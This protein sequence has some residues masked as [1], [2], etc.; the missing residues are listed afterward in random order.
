LLLSPDPHVAEIT[1]L[2]AVHVNRVLKT[3]RSEGMVTLSQRSLVVPDLM[4]LMERAL[5]NPGHL[6]LDGNETFLSAV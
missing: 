5:F 2:T 6:H 3:L 1:G 4:K